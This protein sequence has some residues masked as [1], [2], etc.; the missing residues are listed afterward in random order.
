MEC[1][2]CKGASSPGRLRMDISAEIRYPTKWYSK[3]AVAAIAIIFFTFL[4]TTAIS[5]FLLYRILAPTRTQMELSATDFPGRPEE[6]KFTVPGGAQRGGWFFPGL[7]GAPTIILCHGYGSSRG[8]LLTLATSLQ[9][10]QYNVFMFDFIGHGDNKGYSTM[11]YVEAR[12]LKAAV[13]E[14]KRRDDVD[15]GKFGVW[16]TNIGAYA[17]LAV[18]EQV[19]AIRAVVVESVYD[20]PSDLL[21]IQ[22]DHSG[23]AGIPFLKDMTV[24]AYEWKMKEHKDLP[25]V[26]ANI[27]RTAGVFKLFLEAPEDT[28]L[29]QM[30]RDLYL[31]APEPKQDAVLGQ[32]NYAAM[33]DDAKKIYENRVLSFFLVNLPASAAH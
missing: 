6:F 15:P 31:K 14:L 5:V 2:A 28:K 24:R 12:E 20:Q 19:S 26:S 18:A 27:S 16:G 29:A 10:R 22:I 1:G 7:R 23:L 4:S 3:I 30:T 17:A 33:Q 11:G 32:G 13:D 8:E 9:D 25:P 21:K